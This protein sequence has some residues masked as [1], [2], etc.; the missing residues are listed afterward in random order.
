MRILYCE[1]DVDTAE[2]IKTGLVMQGH[3]VDYA[4]TADQAIQLFDISKANPYDLIIT[5][6]EMPGHLGLV[7]ADHARRNGYKGRIIVFTGHDREQFLPSIQAVEGEY[8]QKASLQQNL[9]HMVAGEGLN[10]IESAPSERE[11]RRRPMRG[12]RTGVDS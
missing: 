12:M 6:V 7:F 3:T 10:Q 8:W 5:D 1:D 11:V 4:Q 2:A 9:E